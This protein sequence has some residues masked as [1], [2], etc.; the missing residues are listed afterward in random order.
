MLLVLDLVGVE[1]RSL[2]GLLYRDVPDPV[3]QGCV[4]G[5]PVQG[6]QLDHVVNEADDGHAA[7]SLL[8]QVLDVQLQVFHHSPVLLRQLGVPV[9]AVGQVL[10]LGPETTSVVHRY[11]GPEQPLVVAEPS[12]QKVLG[13]T[14]ARLRVYKPIYWCFL[15]S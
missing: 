11:H 1:D 7:R 5:A 14:Q 8:L 4:L 6:P 10:K 15:F 12:N 9:A 3:R 2:L 13:L